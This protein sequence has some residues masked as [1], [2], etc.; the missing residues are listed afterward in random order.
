MPEA[1][2][3]SFRRVLAGGDGKRSWML[4]DHPLSGVTY[5]MIGKTPWWGV[6]T[7]RWH[8]VKVDDLPAQLFDLAADPWETT[9]VSEDH[10]WWVQHLRDL[11]APYLYPLE[12]IEPP[13]RDTPNPPLAQPDPTRTAKPKPT[14]RPTAGSIGRP[15]QTTTRSPAPTATPT[16]SAPAAATPRSTPEPTPIWLSTPPPT[17]TPIPLS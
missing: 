14:P 4:E 3:V 12:E 7:Q 5:G 9:N 13:T 15:T 8:L 17:R 10:P 1:D 6:R 16:P 11:A 2:G